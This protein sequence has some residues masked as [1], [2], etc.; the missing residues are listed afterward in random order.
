MNDEIRMTNGEAMTK[1]NNEKTTAFASR[2]AWS[3]GFASS[4]DIRA[5]S[6]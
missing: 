5:S 1:L 3:F 4:F 2:R 6:F